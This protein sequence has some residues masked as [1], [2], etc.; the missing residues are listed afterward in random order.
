M[1]SGPDR[2]ADPGRESTSAAFLSALVTE[3]FVLQSAR[4][5]LTAEST[6]RITIYLGVTSS[7]LIAMGFLASDHDA[8]ITFV[9]TVMPVLFLLGV[10]T[11]VR[12]LQIGVEDVAHLAAIQRIRRRYLTLDPDGPSYFP[13]LPVLPAG[14]AGQRAAGAEALAFMG[15]TGERTQLLFTAATVVA[16]VNSVTGGAVVTLLATAL[17]LPRPA[18]VAMGVALAVVLVAGHVITQQRAYT[19]RSLTNVR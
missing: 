6:S 2:V 7:S 15:L 11:F 18:A 10:L 17:T 13:D 5:V 9:A 8:L 16:L 4:G 14:G 19:G 1:T 3:H 12:L